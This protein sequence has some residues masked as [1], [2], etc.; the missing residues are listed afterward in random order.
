[1]IKAYDKLVRPRMF[2]EG[3]LV[4]KAAEH[5]MKGMNAAK[6]TPKW[7][8]PYVVKEARASGY[9]KLVNPKS[10]HVTAPVNFKYVKKDYP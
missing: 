7:E 5:V 3:D 2:H 8:G 9:C 10:G 4:L 1:M 6:F